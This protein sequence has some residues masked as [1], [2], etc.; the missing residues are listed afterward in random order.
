[1]HWGASCLWLW[2]PW[3]LILETLWGASARRSL[4]APT[5]SYPIPQ[6][7]SRPAAL[8]PLMDS[9]GVT[10]LGCVFQHPQWPLSA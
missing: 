2:E 1:M 6:A 10:I 9:L 7:T 8:S 3:S 4:S 5:T